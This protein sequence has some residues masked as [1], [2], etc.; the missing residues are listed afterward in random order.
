M[1]FIEIKDR[2]G[3]VHAVNTDTVA[4]M[5]VDK[6]TAVVWIQLTSRMYIESQF[7]DIYHAVDYIQRAPSMSLS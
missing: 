2:H 3:R 1:R 4:D 7:T 6:D 5:Y